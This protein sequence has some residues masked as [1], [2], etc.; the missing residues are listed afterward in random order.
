MNRAFVLQ[1]ARVGPAVVGLA[2]LG[3]C[4]SPRSGGATG[5]TS[6]VASSSGLPLDVGSSGDVVRSVN[7][8]LTA[9]GYFPNA[10]LAQA[11]SQW[12]PI[13]PVAPADPNV[14]DAR[15]ADAVTALQENAGLPRSGVVDEETLAI[16]RMPRCGNPDGI[17]RD[18]A[19]KYA[20]LRD[21]GTLS[22][23]GRWAIQPPTSFNINYAVT[24][25]PSNL[26]LS[27]VQ[28]AVATALVSGWSHAM[29]SQIQFTDTTGQGG[30]P[31]IAITFAASGPGC[32][33]GTT[34]EGCTNLSQNSGGNITGAT[35][36]LN[37]VF[38]FAVGGFAS[39]TSAD[40]VSIVLHESGHALGLAHSSFFSASMYPAAHS[41]MPES[42]SL[43]D[44]VGTRAL[45]QAFTQVSSGLAN[46]IGVNGA[47][48]MP[49]G[50]PGPPTWVLGTN[51]VG[52]GWGVFHFQN[53]IWFM[54]QNGG[55]GETIAVGP[56]DVPWVTNFQGVVMSK[57]SGDPSTGTWANLGAPGGAASDIAV[58][59]SLGNK[60][61]AIGPTR[62]GNGA[63]YAWEGPNNPTVWDLDNAGGA[64]NRIAVDAVGFPHVVN[65]AGAIFRKTTNNATSGAWAELPAPAPG[66]AAVDIGIN[67]DNAPT[68]QG[69]YIWVTGTDGKVYVWDE[70]QNTTL[71]D[72]AAESKWIAV[73]FSLSGEAQAKFISVGPNGQPWVVDANKGIWQGNY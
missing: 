26:S 43:D 3:A 70:Q 50:V 24:N 20:L 35:I 64:A 60:A 2:T 40:L 13:V 19:D 46:D 33:A 44:I 72:A 61:W 48:F 41:G 16:I 14:Y 7:A 27:Q 30:T 49:A 1:I 45:Y 29:G 65:A 8:Y 69:D 37:T 68:N 31:A 15:T 34:W 67:N 51:V 53:G 55:A 73:P 66:V 23:P 63:I 62:F 71:G 36:T 59:A 4:G 18:A 57:A 17:P 22:A 9:F 56:N 10:D 39:A 38:T 52:Q 47:G 32:P 54:D 6:V 21:T 42:P 5:S 11:F 25:A 28:T 12:R 58:S